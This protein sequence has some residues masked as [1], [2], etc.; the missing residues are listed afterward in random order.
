MGNFKKEKKKR[1]NDM[2]KEEPK[3]D[4]YIVSP[5][6]RQNVENLYSKYILMKAHESKMRA[7]VVNGPKPNETKGKVHERKGSDFVIEPSLK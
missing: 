2:K 1:N 6:L 7:F 4:E 3:G 5:C